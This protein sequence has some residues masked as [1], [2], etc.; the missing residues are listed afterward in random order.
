[1]VL[2]AAVVVALAVG[3]LWL[4][5]QHLYRTSYESGYSYDVVL[6]TNETLENATLYVPIPVEEGKPNLSAA[7]VEEGNAAGENFSYRVV[8]TEYGPRLEVTADRVTVTPRYYEFVERNGT[9]ERVEIPE[10]EY[11]PSDPDMTRDANA[12]TLVT[13]TVPANESVATDDPWGVERC[14]RRG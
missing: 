5:S 8:E 3:G 12:G 10:S 13:V 1:M 9:V 14:S 11:D 2:A 7:M 6:N 4:Y